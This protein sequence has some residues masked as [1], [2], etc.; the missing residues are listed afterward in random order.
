MTQDYSQFQRSPNLV[1][2]AR[3]SSRLMPA[4]DCFPL[5]LFEV[6]HAL[7]VAGDH[8]EAAVA[9]HVGED[10]GMRLREAVVDGVLFELRLAF[11][12][13]YLLPPP[14]ADVVRGTGDH[15]GQAVT[16]HVVDQDLGAVGPELRGD[17]VPGTAAR[18]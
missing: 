6:E 9:V 12:A 16:I 7:L 4:V 8:V 17:E 1:D 10:Q 3:P 11:R 5:L 18:I 2:C 14:D 13:S 15:V